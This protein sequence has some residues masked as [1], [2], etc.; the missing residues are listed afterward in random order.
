M[1][2]ITGVE[3]KQRLEQGLANWLERKNAY[4]CLGKNVNSIDKSMKKLYNYWVITDQCVLTDDEINCIVNDIKPICNFSPV[5]KVTPN[6]VTM[7]VIIPTEPVVE[8]SVLT[9][10]I[11][12]ESKTCPTISGGANETPTRWAT[13]GQWV[14]KMNASGGTAPYAYSWTCINLPTGAGVGECGDAWSV[15]SGQLTDTLTLDNVLGRWAYKWRC[16]VIDGLG[17]SVYDEI[18]IN[19]SSDSCYSGG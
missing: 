11:T 7:P 10:S 19:T 9:G 13:D 15:P 2:A 17:N 14:I 8:A 5:K 12:I 6:L 4:L 3:L 1:A 18:T 16:T